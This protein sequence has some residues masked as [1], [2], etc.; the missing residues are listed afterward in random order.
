MSET[1]IV[2]VGSRGSRGPAGPRG[3]T[4]PTGPASPNTF[5][6]IASVDMPIGTP[7]AWSRTVL[8]EVQPASATSGFGDIALVAGLTTAAVT[9][10]N[11]V[12]VQY[13]G[14]I[15]L[16]PAQWDAVVTGGSGGL[17]FGLAYWL[18]GTAGQI[19]ST[20]PGGLNFDTPIGIA[21][22]ATTLQLQISF[23]VPP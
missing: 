21:Q 10:G 1:R 9:A 15:T 6:A 3:P 22:S 14:L 18:S 20:E 7:V 2:S 13:A 11:P 23:P 19:T 16:T 17:T 4:G 5:T 12:V 8:G